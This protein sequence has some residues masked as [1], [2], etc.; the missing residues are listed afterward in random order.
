MTRAQ[1]YLVLCLL[2]I[3]CSHAADGN[4]AHVAALIAAGIECA[5]M[6]FFTIADWKS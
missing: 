3:L 1:A 6:V 4:V 2:F 5:G